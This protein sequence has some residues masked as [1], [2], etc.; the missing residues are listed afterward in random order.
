MFVLQNRHRKKACEIEQVLQ[1]VPHAKV[2][3]HQGEVGKKS[4][5][6][7]ESSVIQSNSVITNSSGPV[8][9]VPYNRGSL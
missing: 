1:V 6:R 8:K 4:G 7:T 9:F 2:V 3:L 5:N